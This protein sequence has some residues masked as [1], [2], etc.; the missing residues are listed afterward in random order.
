MLLILLLADD[1]DA[2]VMV[3]DGDVVPRFLSLRRPD[4]AGVDDEDDDDTC[5]G[6]GDAIGILAC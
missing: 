5:G 1:G 4:V 3:G 2:A 6:A